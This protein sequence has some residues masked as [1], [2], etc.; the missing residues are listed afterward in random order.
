ML[1]WRIAGND[2]LLFTSDTV[3]QG[4]ACNC[5]SAL[6]NVY[7]VFNDWFGVEPA[8]LRSP[9]SVIMG[10][11]DYPQ[12]FKTTGTVFLTSDTL[13]NPNMAVYQFAHEL[14]H[15]LI[16]GN[17]TQRFKWFEETICRCASMSA[18]RCI[19]GASCTQYI[20]DILSGN[21]MI[22]EGK[23]VAAY[24]RSVPFGPTKQ[25]IIFSLSSAFLRASS[26]IRFITHSFLYSCHS[27][28]LIDTFT[29]TSAPDLSQK[30]ISYFMF[31]SCAVRMVPLTSYAV[32]S[33]VAS[34]R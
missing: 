7:N 12:C 25:A 2:W 9:V 11:Q 14:C 33:S 22:P 24:I 31:P 13:H 32:C 6:N 17:V 10:A 20:N 34:S 29:T 27:A 30:L 4:I 1:S 8:S 26:S 19:Y 5:V 21:A 15:L 18:L 16:P 28:T 23:S 3:E